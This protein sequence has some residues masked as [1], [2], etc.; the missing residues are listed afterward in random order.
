MSKSTRAS[1]SDCYFRQRGSVRPPRGYAVPDVPGRDG[2][3]ARAAASSRSSYCSRHPRSPRVRSRPSGVS[4]SSGAARRATRRAGRDA[5]TPIPERTG[6]RGGASAAGE[7]VP[8]FPEPPLHSRPCRRS[9]RRPSAARAQATASEL[10]KVTGTVRRLGAKRI[11]L[12]LLAA[13][14]R[15]AGAVQ[16][17]LRRDQLRLLLDEGVALRRDPARRRGRVSRRLPVRQPARA[18]S[19]DVSCLA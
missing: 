11:L 7:A 12:I 15:P 8:H 16:P 3:P 5:G 17:E 9:T 1:C 13:L 2:R 4:G 18:A 6:D 19:E 10:D 14:R